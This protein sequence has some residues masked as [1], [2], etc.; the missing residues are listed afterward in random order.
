MQLKKR[1]AQPEQALQ[2]A[3][4]TWLELQRRARKLTYFAV[5]N[6]GYRRKREAWLL[7][8]MGLRAGIPDMVIGW[9]PA[10]II[11]IEF[12]AA[13]GRLSNDQKGIHEELRFFGF[14]VF[15]IR[16]L[17]EL[18]KLITEQKGHTS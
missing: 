10:K 18:I 5:P 4:T 2:K 15:V 13:T 3:C 8:L 12:K 14:S 11:F 9:L 6:G 1:K 17:D 16:N 7:Q